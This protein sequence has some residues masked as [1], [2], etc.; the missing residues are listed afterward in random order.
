MSEK[1]V[2]ITGCTH[3]GIGHSLALDFHTRGYTVLASARR[4]SQIADLAERGLT[5]LS[6]DVTDRNSIEDAKREVEALIADGLIA[7]LD[8]L[9]NNAGRNCTMPALDVD[10]DDARHCFETNVFGV[11][12]MCQAFTPLLIKQKGLIVNI[13]SVAAIIPYVFGSTYNASKAAL[14]A[15]SRTLRLE[16]APLGVR[17][18]VVV[19][20]GVQSNIARTKRTLPPSSLY[21]D[22][23]DDFQRRVV[24]S[25]DGAM[26]NREF[27]RGVVDAV[28]RGGRRTLWRGNKSW[29]VWF[30]RSWVGG[31][32]FDLL[33]PSMFGLGRLGGL[34]RERE[35][36]GG[37]GGKGGK[38]L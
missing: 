19:T 18:M 38:G 29:L 11:M 25:Q 32:I 36:G 24:H 2:L 22:I 16:L 13:G 3:G 17:V 7:G 15:Y 21:L 35:R 34:V 28:V 4:A 8:V 12:A 30:A 33:L 26:A 23:E 1:T 14:H 10:L 6:L 37:K 27:A 9:V 31:W 5:T 20:G